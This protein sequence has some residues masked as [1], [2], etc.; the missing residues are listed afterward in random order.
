M[1][2]MSKKKRPRNDELFFRHEAIKIAK[3]LGYNE[4]TIRKIKCS[5]SELEAQRILADARHAQME[6]DETFKDVWK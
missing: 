3:Q 2:A 1:T 6:R 4:N 5:K